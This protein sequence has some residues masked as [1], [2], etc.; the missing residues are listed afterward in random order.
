MA[1]HRYWRVRGLYTQSGLIT[2]IGLQFR[3]VAGG[4]SVVSGGTVIKSSEYNNTSYAAT[5]AFDAGPGGNFWASST[6]TNGVEWV[7]YDFGAGNEKDIVEITYTSPSADGSVRTPLR[8]AIEFSD[9]GATW[10]NAFSYYLGSPVAGTV[11]TITKPTFAA[12]GHRAWRFRGLTNNGDLFGLSEMGMRLVSGGANYAINSTIIFYSSYADGNSNYWANAAADGNA[13]NLYIAAGNSPGVEWVGADFGIGQKPAFVEFFISAQPGT[14]N[15]TP[16]SVAVEYSDDLAT[17]TL[18]F[19]QALG[20][21][22]SGETKTFAAPPPAAAAGIQASEGRTLTVF[23]SLA[24]GERMT[25]SRV[26]SIYNF[27]SIKEHASAARVLLPVT[28]DVSMQ[29]SAA[30]VMMVVRGRTANPRLRVWTCTLDG[31]D[32]FFLRLGDK[33]TLVYDVSTQTWTDWD[34]P[35]SGAWRANTGITWAGGQSLGYKY[36]SSVVCGDDT[37]GLLWFLD[38]KLGWD[39]NP[40]PLR[41][42]VEIPFTR[43][44]TG[45]VVVNGREYHPCYAIFVS[46]D[47][48]GLTAPSFTPS[49]TLATS[50]DQGREWDDHETLTYNPNDDQDNPYQWQSLGQFNSPGRLFRLTDN[51]LYTRIDSMEMNDDDG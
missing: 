38:P 41:L 48:Y 24:A 29:I 28:R 19:T 3:T 9:D 51:G 5:H 4:P 10:T 22:T 14:S 32:F 11:L 7:G 30:R 36:G 33:S 12:G 42:P 15:R 2:A 39:Q 21:F 31:H 17:W 50:D 35:Q 8:I 40:D 34:S 45:Q 13:G 6:G 26:F 46:G 49:I 16:N 47:N 43:I 1:V 27:P 23:S 37:F 18:A 25:S 20:T 44:V